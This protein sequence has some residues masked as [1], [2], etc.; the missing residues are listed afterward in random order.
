MSMLD[1]IQTKRCCKCKQFKPISE[2]HKDKTR[3]DE[4]F[5]RCKVCCSKYVKKYNKSERYKIIRKQYEQSEEGKIAQ[6]RYHQ[7]KKG[8]VKDK[9]Y[10]QSKKGKISSKRYYSHH[11][12]Q[13][14]ARQAI[15]NA[16]RDNRLPPPDTRLC[17]YCPKPSQHY[18]HW[19]GYEKEHWLDVIPVCRDCHSKCKRKIA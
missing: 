14:K 10:A 15:Y 17:H 11:P 12:K 8:K 5:C 9:R 1:T 7:S 18:H 4:H 19:H 13:H 6:K 2:F 16:I 3:K